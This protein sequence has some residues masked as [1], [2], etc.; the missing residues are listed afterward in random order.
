[1][2]KHD[3]SRRTKSDSRHVVEW[4]V[5]TLGALIVCGSIVFLGYKA[6]VQEKSPPDITFHTLAIHRVAGGYLVELRVRNNGNATAAK[7]KIRGLL[8]NGQRIVETSEANFDFVPSQSERRGGLFF[9]NNPQEYELKI[10]TEGY[11]RP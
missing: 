4:V 7:L 10:R 11:E 9:S 2:P 6:A 5:G 3:R 1:M 8:M